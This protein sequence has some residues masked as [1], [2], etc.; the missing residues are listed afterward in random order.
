ME[1]TIDKEIVIDAA[2]SPTCNCCVS[3]QTMCAFLARYSSALFTSASTC[4]R[5]EKNVSRIAETYGMSVEI[6]ILPRHIHLTVHDRDFNEIV[7]TIATIGEGPISFS[8][9]TRLSIL[10]WDIADGKINFEEAKERMEHILANPERPIFHLPAIVGCANASFCYLFGGDWTAMAIVF[11]ATFV[12]YALKE[13]LGA[14]GVDY[15]LTV[16]ICAFVSTVLAAS[17]SLFGLG[18]TP[19]IAVATSVLYLVPGIPF[20]NS[21][22]DMLDRHYICAF[23]RAMN[24]MVLTFCLSIGLGL[25]MLAMGISMF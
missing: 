3:A 6:T 10:S 4:I 12:G 23:G 22:S 21:L 18:A 9:N 19:Q 1:E 14:K 2:E 5:L 7:T 20:I 8:L 13:I 25:G 17:D 16:V 24:A 11:V 15:R